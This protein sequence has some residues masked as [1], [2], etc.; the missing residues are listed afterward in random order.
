MLYQRSDLRIRDPFVLPL[1][2]D[3]RYLLFGSTGGSSKGFDCFSSRDLEEWEGPIAAF[4]PTP[5]FWANTQFW[6]PECH[7]WQGHYYL[8]ATFARDKRERGTQILIADQPDG[9]YLPHSDGPVTPRGWECLDGTLFIDDV[10]K[11]W[12]V[13]CR[14]WVQVEDGEMHAIP[15]SDDLSCAIG[16]PTFL[17]RASEASW[18]TPLAVEGDRHNNRVTDGPFLFRTASGPLLLL[19]STIGPSGYA[20]GYAVSAEGN[21]R[22]PWVQSATPLFAQDGGH[23]MIFRDFKGR[24]LLG[25]HQPNGSSLERAQ[26]LEIEERDGGLAMVTQL[27]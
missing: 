6:A 7:V 14:E 5:D 8:L 9:P 24:L 16:A 2:A 25:L 22:G 26:W 17:F 18:S 3:G 21:I 10:R 13:F 12:M 19:W 27:R 20:L 4:R 11:P 1:P 23:G 15:L